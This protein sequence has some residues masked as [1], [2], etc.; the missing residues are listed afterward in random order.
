MLFAR[1]PGIA[2]AA[3]PVFADRYHFR[4]LT[5]LMLARET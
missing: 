2:L 4:G 1:L 5:R 3:P